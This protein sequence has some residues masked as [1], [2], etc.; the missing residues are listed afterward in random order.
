LYATSYD[1]KS[2]VYE[3]V[4][5][6]AGVQFRMDGINV[7]PEQTVPFSSTPQYS[8]YR[9]QFDTKSLPNGTHVVTAV[10]RDKAGNSVSSA[11]I[12]FTVNNR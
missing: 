1:V 2:T 4:S 5:G 12:T 8:T 11:G 6:V 3:T 9:L 7:G 10:A